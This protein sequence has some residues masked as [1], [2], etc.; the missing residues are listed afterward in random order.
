MTYTWIDDVPIY[1]Q[2]MSE[3]TNWILAGKIS[4]GDLLP[5]ARK[6]ASQYDVNPLTAVKAYQE[7][8]NSNVL[9]KRRGIG[10]IVRDGAAKMVRRIEKEKFL[11]E[12]WPKILERM[13]L[14]DVDPKQL[15]KELDGC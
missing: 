5:S 7:L 1:R 4:D 6:L 15:L 13:K 3:I 8:T 14:M 9:D 2:L 11:K 10:I 12:E